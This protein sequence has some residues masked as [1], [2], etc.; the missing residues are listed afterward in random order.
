MTANGSEPFRDEKDDEIMRHWNNEQRTVK[1]EKQEKQKK[2]KKY[3]KEEEDKGLG[4]EVKQ[5]IHTY[6]HTYI[7]R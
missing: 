7:Y 6:I 3:W 5:Y 1:D 2:Q 4:R